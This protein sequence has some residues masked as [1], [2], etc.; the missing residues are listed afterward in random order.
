M[1][2]CFAIFGRCGCT[3]TAQGGKLMMRKRAHSPESKLVSNTLFKMPTRD[4]HV[5]EENAIRY[6]DT[7]DK[8]FSDKKEYRSL[9][10]PNGLQAL[11]IS[12][13]WSQSH[14]ANNSVVDGN[15]E[16]QSQSDDAASVTS[17]ESER[18]ESD[19]ESS[20]GGDADPDGEKLAAAALCIDV[21]SFSD[22]RNVQGLAH[23]LEHMIFM[24]SKKYPTENEYDA[25]INK[26]GGFDNAV[27]DLE[28]TTFYFEIDEQYLDGA[29]DRFSNLFASPLML[30]DS[31]CRERDA[32]ES[33]FQ[34]NINSFSSMQDQLFA[35]MGK[36]D[37]P[38]S[39][40]TWGNLQTLKNNITDDE[41]YEVLHQFQQRHYSAHRMYFAVQ[42]RM[43]LDELEQLTVKYF[44]NIPNNNLPADDFSNFN[45]RNAFKPEFYNKVFFV[46]PKSNM[47]QLDVTWCLPSSVKDY[48]VK[49]VDVLSYHLG[50][51]GKHSLTSYLRKR[52]L[53]LDVQTGA[54]FGYDRN[55]LYTLFSITVTMTDEGLEK[56]DEVLE[57]IFSEV[58]R[59]KEQG[60]V[61]WLFEELKEIE[62][63]SFRF[64]KEKVASD[65]V[66]EL[67][68]NMR[69]YPP[70]HII[71]GPELYFHYDA[72][73]IQEV[74]DNLNQPNF[75]IMISSS[76]PYDGIVFDRKEKWFGTEYATIDMPQK[77]KNLWEN[78]TDIPELKLQ[79]KNN[80]ISTN[81]TILATSHDGS[82]T[83]EIPQ[84]PEKV[85]DNEICEL[86]YRLDSKFNLPSA[87][88]Y[89]YLISPLPL[90]D[91]QSATLSNLYVSLLKFQISEAL[92]PAEA[93]GLNFEVH[94]AEKGIVLKFDGYNEKL[95]LIVDELT[96]AMK[97]FEKNVVSDE[98]NIIKEKLFKHY[99]N[100]IIKASKFSR[101][102][103]LKIVQ[104]T[105]WTVLD[106]LNDLLNLTV[107]DLKLFSKEFFQQI[108]I[109]ALIQGNILK[110]DAI[111]VMSKVLVNLG[112]GRIADKLLIDS[113]AREIPLGNNHVTMQ[114]FRKNDVNTVTTNFYQ[115]GPV[116]PALNA[117]LELLEMLLEEPLFDILRT[118]E[119]LGYD[120][121]VTMRDNFGILGYS[122][123]VH[124]QEDK[125][126]YQHIEERIEDFNSRF[127]QILYNM[128]ETDFELIKNSLL[129]HK[130][131]VD[132][133]LKNEMSRNWAEITTEE[134]IFDRNKLEMEHIAKLTKT[135]IQ[136]F[137]RQLQV[138]QRRK[139]SIQVVGCSHKSE[140]CNK[141]ENRDDSANIKDLHRDLKILFLTSDSQ[142]ENFITNIDNF[143]KTLKVF[144]VTKIQF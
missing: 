42:A 126:N 79:E 29:L 107:N 130:Q 117:Q 102:V 127:V 73:E 63:T 69:H 134:Y 76:K 125:F 11:L 62:A 98:F 8:S 33:E 44:S 137:Y 99:Y 36:E 66:E 87:L 60:P 39:L 70:K 123:T 48:K 103:R 109:Q 122:I 38:C 94:S 111:D 25:Y 136:H 20:D 9:I 14:S 118:K 35:S 30:R 52:T 119:Q 106:R 74:I 142:K 116:T 114:S 1:I 105:H 67:V 131:I 139:L 138:E 5:T 100:D 50:Y 135:D 89:F 3:R 15:D 12:E 40:F 53:A 18:T 84:F 55:S 88:M 68:V 19:S 110:E 51:E 78:T 132:T 28:E 81:F 7:P 56:V 80:Y 104:E 82:Q 59:L 90:R 129:K 21:G 96:K 57:A 97:E 124:S 93:A 64:R 143:G 24:G 121:S 101:D 128:P 112:G 108:K 2:A 27:T 54:S 85:M 71:T 37:H 83:N 49:P 6:L 72:A 26:C 13:P 86:W 141:V 77:W 34:T 47:C 144:P 17:T 4:A 95:P 10:L 32:V 75:N 91:P 115:A 133:E 92:Y 113:R 31:I 65:N 45:E 43:S 23:F 16:S 22:P 46:K 41:L 140:K 58:R 120:V 61:E